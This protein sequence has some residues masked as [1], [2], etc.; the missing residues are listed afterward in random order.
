MEDSARSRR[1]WPGNFSASP[2]NPAGD[3]HA[4]HQQPHG[5]GRRVPAARHQAFEQRLLCSLS[6]DM[7]RLW[8]ELLRKRLDLPFVD[9]VRAADK[10]LSN[11]QVVEVE[12][13][14]PTQLIVFAMMSSS[15]WSRC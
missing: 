2:N 7:K 8:V 1:L 6:I 12:D 13:F 11:V 5:D 4:F 3:W 10:S 9:Q 15:C 14:F